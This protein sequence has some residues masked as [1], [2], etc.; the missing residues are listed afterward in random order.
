LPEGTASC[1]AKKLRRTC[2]REASLSSTAIKDHFTVFDCFDGT[3]LAYFKQSTGITKEDPLPPSRSIHD[4]I[5][6]IWANGDRDYNIGC[7]VKRLRRIDKSM[8]PEARTAFAG[9][10]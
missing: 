2:A 6:D 1:L 5:E 7:L 9:L 10:R 4:V 8:S 3:L